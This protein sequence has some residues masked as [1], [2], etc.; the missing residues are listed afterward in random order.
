MV[1]QVRALAEGEV[2]RGPGV[3]AERQQPR[4]H[5]RDV[6][7]GQA[8]AGIGLVDLVQETAHLG[9]GHAQLA[10]RLLVDAAV[11]ADERV[12]APRHH[13]EVAVAAREHRGRVPILG[14]H[15]QRPLADDRPRD[16]DR[17][18]TR[19]RDHPARLEAA[20]H[21]QLLGVGPR[22]VEHGPGAHLEPPA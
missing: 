18:V 17:H 9:L 12:P 11:D 16:H 5:D 20:A 10:R 8:E 6:V 3:L 7:E 15:G 21:Q 13:E 22:R 14:L 2:G 4:V 1:D 19:E